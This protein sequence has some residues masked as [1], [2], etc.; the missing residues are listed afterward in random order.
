MW[1]KLPT[2]G[3]RSICFPRAPSVFFTP[4]V[5]S[6]SLCLFSL[7]LSL[8]TASVSSHSLCLFSLPLSL[9]TPS[10][11][12]VDLEN[13]CEYHGDVFKPDMQDLLTSYNT[14]FDSSFASKQLKIMPWQYVRV[15]ELI[16]D[17][18]SLVDKITSVTRQLGA[19]VR[20]NMEN[21]EVLRPNLTLVLMKN[22]SGVGI[23][24]GKDFSRTLRDQPEVMAKY[25]RFLQRHKQS[26][27][28]TVGAGASLNKAVKNKGLSKKNTH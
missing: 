19:V 26:A 13:N 11:S 27:S 21:D 25:K 10:V 12:P 15:A 4:S 24:Q 18:V 16:A 5:S 17:S 20:S 8:L 28:K 9:L 1:T 6:H 7:P 23:E 14:Q 3:T 22:A 2:A